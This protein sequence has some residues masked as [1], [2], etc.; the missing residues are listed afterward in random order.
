MGKLQERVASY[1]GR[2][3]EDRKRIKEGVRTFYEA[4]SDIVHSG[5]GEASPFTNG[6]AFVTG[7]D[8]ARRSLIKL[9]REGLPDTWE[10][11]AVTQD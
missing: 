2:D 6:A 7:F 4:R 10:V 9:L 11:Q 3:S 5:P 1:I 8:L